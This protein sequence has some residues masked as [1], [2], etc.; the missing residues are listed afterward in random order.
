LPLPTEAKLQKLL[1]QAF[2]AQGSVGLGKKP[3]WLTLVHSTHDPL[4]QNL[5]A[6][7]APGW[8]SGTGSVPQIPLEH[9]AR[10]QGSVG[11]TQSDGD[12]HEVQIPFE[13]N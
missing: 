5:L 10:W 7:Q 12:W 9:V 6:P 8:L 13:Q 3:H 1:T 11:A 4:R 2:T